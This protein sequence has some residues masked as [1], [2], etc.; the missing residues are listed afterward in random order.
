MF[1]L[2]AMDLDLYILVVT[3]SAIVYS[4]VIRAIQFKYVDQT[5]SK[6]LQEKSKKL[7]EELK[8]A[9]KKNDQKKVDEIM[10]K[11]MALIGEMNKVMFSSFKTM[12]PIIA[13]FLI[14]TGI[15]GYFD[16][17]VSDDII[18]HPK[19]DGSG[20]DT[21]AGDNIYSL[22]EPVNGNNGEWILTAS[23]LNGKDFL[24]NDQVVA[25]NSHTFFL[26]EV[27]EKTYVKGSKGED[28]QLNGI[29]DQYNNNEKLE[30][31]IPTNIGIPK[32]TLNSGTWFY[33]DLPVA[34]PLLNI[35]RISEV[36]WWFIFVA[37]ISGIIISMIYKK[38]IKVN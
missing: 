7:N 2:Y 6:E 5:K 12:I 20:C 4:L 16:P 32:V 8:E 28:L 35:Q 31:F 24:G 21:S 9:S 34:I 13:V 18:L 26:G 11:Q 36:Y 19:D 25:E 37:F 22:C 23:I 1:V 10:K 29:K 27:G 3:L 38:F 17:T 30:L 14:F 33:V 15:L